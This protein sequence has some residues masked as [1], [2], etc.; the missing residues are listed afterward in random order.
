MLYREQIPHC[1]VGISR[2][3]S[4]CKS[5]ASLAS[6][7]GHRYKQSRH[8]VQSTRPIQHKAD[9]A[10]LVSHWLQSQ[11]LDNSGLVTTSRKAKNSQVAIHNLPFIRRLTFI[12]WWYRFF[13]KLHCRIFS[14][15]ASA[16]QKSAFRGP[17][18]VIHHWCWKSGQSAHGN[19]PFQRWWCMKPISDL[20]PL[21]LKHCV[22]NSKTVR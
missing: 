4:L 15:S 13:S 6:C 14:L 11:T 19:F 3:F 2:E 8:G 16:V 5:S 7:C 9:K 18:H 20:Y 21:L 17:R 10:A 22:V 1:R 12:Q